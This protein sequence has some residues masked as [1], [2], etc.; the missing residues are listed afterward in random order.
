MI[1]IPIDTDNATIEAGGANV[2]V[3]N[4]RKVFFPKTGATKGR[5]LQYYSDVSTFLLPHIEK[6]AM[7]MKRYPHGANGEFFFMK[8][9]PTP[10]P[11]WLQTCRIEH[12]SGNTIDFPMANDLASLLWIVNLGCID[13]NQWYATCDDI[14]RPDYL[15]FDLDPGEAPFE[16]VR[17][18]ALLVRDGL[19]G[20]GLSSFAK[21][22][23]S[24]GIHVYVPI[25]RGPLQKEVWT[26]AKAFAQAVA[27]HDTALATAEYKKEKRPPGRVLVD[28]NQNRWG[29]TLASV[30]SVR[31]TPLATV[32]APVTWDEVE[33]GIEIEDFRIDNM[34]E[35]IATAG[36]LWS[37]L[38]AEKG[39]CDLRPL[40]D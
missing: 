15:H 25:V 14:D 2:T 34:L 7:V 17:E 28:Y 12:R 26:F 23:G 3:T 8:R 27:R 40:L 18:V 10:H 21:T 31:P 6:R 32:S 22:S 11:D 13:L 29:S 33:R 1:R 39:R 38:A 36:D 24:K 35:R 20:V 37:P 9:T 19:A 16:R 5:L 4:V 30:Y